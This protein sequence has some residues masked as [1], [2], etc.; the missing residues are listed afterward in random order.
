M[1]IYM[2]RTYLSISFFNFF[3]QTQR[4]IVYI[5]PYFVCFNLFHQL[6]SGILKLFWDRD[7]S[8]LSRSQPQRQNRR[9]PFE[10][11]SVSLLQQRVHAPLKTATWATV[12]NQ[13][14]A[15]ASWTAPPHQP[16]LVLAAAG[17][18]AAAA[19]IKKLF[20][21]HSL[22]INKGAPTICRS[23]FCISAWLYLNFGCVRVSWTRR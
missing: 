9:F 23:A 21:N 19:R 11:I 13:R 8:H 5:N 16:A 20:D 2:I 14:L 3:A 10:W 4:S 18:T 17:A 15:R 12:K 1:R 22:I 7:D 6:F